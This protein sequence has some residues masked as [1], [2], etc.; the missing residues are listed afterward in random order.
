MAAK[1]W[2]WWSFLEATLELREERR[3]VLG[4]VGDGRGPLPFIGVGGRGGG[5]GRQDVGGNWRAFMASVTEREGM[6]WLNE[7]WEE[8][9]V[10]SVGLPPWL[11]RWAAAGSGRQKGEKA[12]WA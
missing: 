4:V 11:G 7:G 5:R 9:G 8:E 6:V 3:A 12:R 2:Q 1:W 10:R